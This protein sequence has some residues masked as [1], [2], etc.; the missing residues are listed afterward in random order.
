MSA[1]CASSDAVYSN[2]QIGSFLMVP[3][4]YSKPDLKIPRE[5]Q[6]L[7]DLREF[8]RCRAVYNG[9]MFFRRTREVKP[10]FQERV[11]TLQ[12]PVSP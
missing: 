5:F 10:G 3:T 7:H 8:T 6:I 12:A 9:F 11:N 2:R 4:A 1:V